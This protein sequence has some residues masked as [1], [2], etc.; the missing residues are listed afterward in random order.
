MSD[1]QAVEF[2]T[3]ELAAI[4]LI[5]PSKVVDGVKVLVP[6]AYPM[7]DVDYES[8]VATIREYLDAVREPRDVRP[9]RPAPLQQPG[10]LDVDG[11]ARDPEPR[12]RRQLTTSGNV[13]TEADY[14][15]EGKVMEGLLDF[16]AGDAAPVERVS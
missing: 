7:Y 12:R 4:G 16:S 3:R 1:E 11:A 2:A 9:E 15:E 10:P 14:L 8:A 13:N 5:D 6:K